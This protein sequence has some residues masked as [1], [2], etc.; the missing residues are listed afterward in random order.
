MIYDV[1]WYGDAFRNLEKIW[2]EITPLAP[3]DAAF[4]EIERRLTKSPETEGESRPDGRRILTLPPLG[5]LFR[6]QPRLKE[7]YVLK[8]WYIRPRH[9]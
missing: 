4:D 8:V 7:V 5:V 1:V 9:R 2:D 6:P 3:A